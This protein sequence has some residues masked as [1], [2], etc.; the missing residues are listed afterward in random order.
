MIK[1][2]MVRLDGTAADDLRLDIATRI[3]RTFD[4]RIIGL[5]LNPLPLPVAPA[6]DGT[7]AITAAEMYRSAK[8][9]GDLLETLLSQRLSELG[10]PIELRRFDVIADEIA[11]V[12]ARQ[13]RSADVFVALRPNGVMEDPNHLVEGVLFGSGRH[14]FLTPDKRSIEYSFKRVLIAWNGSRE[15]ARALAEALPYLH[16]AETVTVVV[17]D[18]FSPVEEQALVGSNAVN[19]LRHHGIEANLR[20]VKSKTGSTPAALL[21]EAKRQKATLIVMGGYGHSRLREWL[22]GGVTYELLHQAPVG[23]IV[24][25]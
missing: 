19:H 17:V 13:A 15:S 3:A 23:L 24:A 21:A 9:A 12:A 5:I 6:V 8:E 14:L 20:H 16:Q 18:E 2:V 25:H 11:A 1:D 22:L 7:G 4:G 10:S